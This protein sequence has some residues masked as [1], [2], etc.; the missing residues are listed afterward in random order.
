MSRF[1]T[2]LK[3]DKEVQDKLPQDII[4]GGKIIDGLQLIYED[5]PPSSKKDNFAI[6]IAETAS[7]LLKGI[8]SLSIN[9]IPH[10]DIENEIAEIEE[11]K[12]EPKQQQQTQENAKYD[13]NKGKDDSDR[14]RFIKHILTDIENLEF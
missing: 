2:F 8:N 14:K 10:E 3:I 9:G 12:V 1:L 7:I 11:I 4:E 13:D 6:V 5:M